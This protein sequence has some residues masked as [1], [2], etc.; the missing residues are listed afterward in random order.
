MR[1]F[2]KILVAVEPSNVVAQTTDELTPPSEH[3]LTRAT[4]LASQTGAELTIFSTVG[5]SPFMEDLLREQLAEGGDAP[6]RAAYELLERRVAQAKQKGVQA[7]SKVAVGVPWQEICREV[8]AEEYD[9]VIVGTRDLGHVGRILFGSTGMKLLRNCSAPV[10]ITRPGLR[11]GRFEILVPSDFSDASQSALRFAMETGRFGHACIHLLHVVDEPLTPPTWYSHVPPQIVEDYIAARRANVKK[12]LH[13]QLAQVGDRSPQVAVQVHVIEG[14]PDE[15]ILQAIDDL[16]INL[17][18]MGTA[19]RSGIQRI[20]L[21][22]TTERLISH[23]RCSLI[24][25][26][27]PDFQRLVPVESQASASAPESSMLPARVL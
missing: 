8:Q 22:N 5:L 12:K 26:K 18:V 13:D 21:G 14:Q 7:R 10:W 16:K 17:V 4:W 20:V 1:C 9:V 19:G 23:M 2:R 27:A 24:A 6:N 11:D 15:T 25:V 3:A